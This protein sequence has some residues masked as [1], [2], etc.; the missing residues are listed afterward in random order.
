MLFSLILSLVVAIILIQVA[1]FSTTIYLH[2]TATH[3]ALILHPG[4]AWALGSFTDSAR[5]AS[6]A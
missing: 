5:P 6:C 3:R 1:V 2:R 4:V